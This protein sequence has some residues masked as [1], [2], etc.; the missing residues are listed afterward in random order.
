[1]KVKESCNSLVILIGLLFVDSVVEDVGV[2]PV[3]RLQTIINLD[4]ALVK[5]GTSLC[6]REMA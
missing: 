2:S 4:L 3:Y 1:M 5:T 6:T